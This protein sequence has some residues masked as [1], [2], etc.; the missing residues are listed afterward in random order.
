MTVAEYPEYSLSRFGL[1]KQMG[2]DC[3]QR[4]LPPKLYHHAQPPY[5]DGETRRYLRLEDT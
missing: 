4:R 5:C 1:Y 2:L 3:W